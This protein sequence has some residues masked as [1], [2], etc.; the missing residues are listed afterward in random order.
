MDD[1]F[2]GE[3]RAAFQKGDVER[4]EKNLGELTINYRDDITEIPGV[5][6]RLANEMAMND[7]SIIDSMICHWEHIVIVKEENL[8]RALRVII[9]L[10]K[11]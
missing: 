7:I 5:F 9:N 6:A 10:T 3:V 1:E 8:E 2:L 4:V 11:S